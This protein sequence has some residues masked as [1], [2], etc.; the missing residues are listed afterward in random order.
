LGD[1]SKVVAV[2]KLSAVI[3]IVLAFV[4]LQEQFTAKSLIGCALIGIGTILMII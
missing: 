1:A 2:D 4:V 3:T